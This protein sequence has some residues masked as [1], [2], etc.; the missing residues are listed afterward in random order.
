MIR[1]PFKVDLIIPILMYKLYRLFSCHSLDVY[2]E[3]LNA[4]Y[5]FGYLISV[6]DPGTVFLA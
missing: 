6:I 3:D 1:K 4:I 5:A 2:T